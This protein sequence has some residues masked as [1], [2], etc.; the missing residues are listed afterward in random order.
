MPE[1]LRDR[2]EALI[3][4]L[5]LA[6]INTISDVRPLTGGVASDIAVVDL[7]GQK[8]C[9][10]FALPK[11]KVAEDWQAPVHRNKAEYEWLKTAAK[12]APD[13]AVK[14]LGRSE[15]MHGFAMEFI[16]GEDVALWKTDLL[17][18]HGSLARAAAV[19]DL[20][21]QIHQAS[22]NA[23]FD[24]KPFQNRDDFFALR[25]EPYLTFT[26]QKHPKIASIL[27]DLAKQL[28]E[29]DQVLVHGD[30]SPKN[31]LFKGALPIIL[32]AECAT[33][34][35]PEF[36]VAFCLNHLIL[37]AQHV[38]TLRDDLRGTVSAFWKAYSAYV[39]WEN[40]KELGKRVSRLLP[41]LMLAR[42]DGKS[43]VEY[44][45][46]ENR[47]AIRDLSVSLVKFPENSIDEVVGIIDVVWKEENL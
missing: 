13:S 15:V 9:I 16:A 25:I 26:S 36:D 10:K 27:K 21:G 47:T 29:S 24:R 28:Y 19:G 32:D 45:T 37:K 8:I 22:S 31:I 46:E 12:I 2:C 11:L 38:S 43:P 23:E 18:G 41:A 14:M 6:P 4:E 35:A 39:S 20:L 40:S 33:M 34:G 1:V 17:A 42:V 44:L 30:V 3:Q 7:Q 5:E